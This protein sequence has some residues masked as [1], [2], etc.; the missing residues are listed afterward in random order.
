MGKNFLFI[1][2]IITITFW[3]ALCHDFALNFYVFLARQH[4]GAS[5]DKRGVCVCVSECVVKYI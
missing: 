3:R 2:Y 4:M 5:K 1:L